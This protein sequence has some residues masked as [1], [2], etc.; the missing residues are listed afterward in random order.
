MFSDCIPKGIRSREFNHYINNATAGMKSFPGTTSK[1]LAHYVVPT[2]QE[3]WFNSALINI[4]IN[5]ILKDQ[6]DSQCESFTQNIL[7]I[8]QKCKE[9][10]VEEI[11]SS[12]VVT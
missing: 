11:I 5:V 6:S 12:I 2:L 3:E 8:S 7:E 4:G 9:H 1:E 10:G